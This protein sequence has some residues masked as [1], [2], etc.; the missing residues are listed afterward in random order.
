MDLFIA[1]LL[2]CAAILVGGIL[3]GGVA[4]AVHARA[5]RRERRE[6]RRHLQRLELAN[7]D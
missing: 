2:A 3:M 6:M 7:R 1:A 4:V 5:G